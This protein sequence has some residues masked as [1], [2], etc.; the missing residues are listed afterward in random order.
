MVDE[1]DQAIGRVLAA[2]WWPGRLEGGRHTGF[3][4][5]S[6]VLPTLLEAIGAAD[7][8]PPDL[9]GASQWAALV[10][11][12]ESARPDYLV[13]GADGD[14]LYRPPWKLT[15]SDP[16]RLHDVYSDPTEERDVAARH[17]TLVDALRARAAGWPSRERPGATSLLGFL[18]DPDRFGGP[19]DR[20]P[21][22]AAALA[23]DRTADYAARV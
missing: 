9:D 2:I 11:T 14:A 6:D 8:I 13:S 20:V 16:P 17:P 1:L 21:W 22:L 23:R 15:L 4:S 12:G 19:E 7:A 5:A 18:L 3:V 10:G